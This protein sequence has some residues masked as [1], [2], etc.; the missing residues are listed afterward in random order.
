MA[1]VRGC[2]GHEADSGSREADIIVIG[3]GREG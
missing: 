3:S 1:A 2:G